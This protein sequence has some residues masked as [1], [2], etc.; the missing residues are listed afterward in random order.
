MNSQISTIDT[1]RLQNHFYFFGF[2]SPIYVAFAY[3]TYTLGGAVGGVATIKW[4]GQT[5]GVR[6]PRPPR[7]PPPGTE[8]GDD[9]PT[10]TRGVHV[11]HNVGR[12]FTLRTTRG[13][14]I[15]SYNAE[16]G[17]VILPY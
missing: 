1:R 12:Q 17:G 9:S 6:T 8:A 5:S 13:P 16:A 11:G 7:R 4:A 10:H 3:H 15:E 14:Q 2:S